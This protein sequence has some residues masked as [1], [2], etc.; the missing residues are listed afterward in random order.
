MRGD[1][2]RRLWDLMPRRRHAAVAATV[3][4]IA[5]ATLFFSARNSKCEDSAALARVGDEVGVIM[6]RDV[7]ELVARVQT[8]GGAMSRRNAF[9][10]LLWQE[11]ERQRLGLPGGER[12]ADSRREVVF[13]H[14][15]RLREGKATPLREDRSSLPGSTTL[16]KCGRRL[17][18]GGE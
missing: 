7:R 1:P 6:I 8:A 17:L 10:D 9:L 2:A 14:R 13:I 18:E 12:A 16:S 4:A 5:L 3:G 11:S 15:D